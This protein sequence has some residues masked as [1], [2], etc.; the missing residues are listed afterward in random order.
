[1]ATDYAEME[2]EFIAS[3][4]ADTGKSLEEWMAAIA[5]SGLTDRNDVIDWLR[6]R[7]FHFSRAS[8]IERIHH[9]GGRLIYAGGATVS[10]RGARDE[11]PRRPQIAEPPSAAPM[12]TAPSRQAD[13]IAALLGN[14]KG[15]RPLADLIV[16]E[17]AAA[18]PGVQIEARAPLIVAT[19][20]SDFA[21]LWPQSK[22]LR[23][24][25]DFEPGGPVDVR[26]AEAVNKS[27]APFPRMMLLDDARRV[28]ATFRAAVAQALRRAGA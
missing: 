26:T 13:D 17:L 22:M 20:K 12:Q 8:W 16:R 1:M 11:P 19:R 3:L 6:H 2:R 27:A 10:D 23:L 7:G 14:A 15:L 4:A 5:A 24:F 9:N 25:G 18:A 28:D 21:A